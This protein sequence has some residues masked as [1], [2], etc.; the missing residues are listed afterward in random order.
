MTKLMRPDT[1]TQAPTIDDLTWVVPEPGVIEQDKAYPLTTTTPVTTG[2]NPIIA[3]E[4]AAL[5]KL[6]DLLHHPIGTFS[7]Q[8][9]CG[10]VLLVSYTPYRCP[11]PV[12]PLP[13]VVMS[14]T[15]ERHYR[16]F[17]RIVESWSKYSWHWLY[18][19]RA[20]RALNK[21]CKDI[22]QSDLTRAERMYMKAHLA[23]TAAKPYRKG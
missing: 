12:L 1:C 15:F 18:G 3:I 23:K 6:F 19:Q 9:Q 10:R 14:R 13:L 11:C 7:I 8:D 17:A 5:A 21:L 2:A 4:D 16:H 22:D 20:S